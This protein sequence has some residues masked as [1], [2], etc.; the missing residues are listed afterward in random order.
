M[1]EAKSFCGGGCV[2]NWSHGVPCLQRRGWAVAGMPDGAGVCVQGYM[3]AQDTPCLDGSGQCT[4]RCVPLA[5]AFCRGICP[6]ALDYVPSSNPAAA[7]APDIGGLSGA[8]LAAALGARPGPSAGRSGA[9]KWLRSQDAAGQ[10]PP[11]QPE[12][13]NV[14]DLG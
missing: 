3:C 4:Q 8:A 11:V 12:I 13:Q 9:S 2:H 7:A 14:I 10:A 1:C 5:A 6:N